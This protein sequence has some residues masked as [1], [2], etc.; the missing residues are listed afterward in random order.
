MLLTIMSA[1]T[2]SPKFLFSNYEYRLL[3]MGGMVISS[4]ID[5]ELGVRWPSSPAFGCWVF[6]CVFLVKT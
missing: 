4:R 1:C 2:C 6:K 3:L 5:A